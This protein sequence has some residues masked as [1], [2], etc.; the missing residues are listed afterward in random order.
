MVGGQWS[1]TIPS[2]RQLLLPTD[3][4]P[5]TVLYSGELTLRDAEGLHVPTSLQHFNPVEVVGN[6]DEWSRLRT[7]RV[8]AATLQ[9]LAPLHA[10]FGSG[11]LIVKIMQRRS[12]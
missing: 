4:P 2:N 8:R 5:T 3:R 1:A 12:Q 9:D 10:Y 7:V 11:H 6:S